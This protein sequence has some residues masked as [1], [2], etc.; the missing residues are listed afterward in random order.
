MKIKLVLYV[1]GLLQVFVGLSMILPVAYALYYGESVLE[2]LIWAMAATIAGG[3]ALAL[4]TRQETDIRVSEG[5]AIVT[6]GWV[7][8]AAFGSLPF[9][10]TGSISSVTDAYFETLSGFTT[11]GASILSDIEALPRSLLLWRSLTQWLG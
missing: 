9:L 3:L 8:S 2:G 10:F 7:L 4:L 5:F 6:F 11:T 1:I